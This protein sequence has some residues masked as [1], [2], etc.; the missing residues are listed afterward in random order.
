MRRHPM[1]AN[2]VTAERVSTTMFEVTQRLADSLDLGRGRMSGETFKACALGVG[3]VLA[4]IMYEVLYPVF[5]MHPSLEPKG[6]K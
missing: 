6:W 1:L 5:A 3:A 2:V 4:D